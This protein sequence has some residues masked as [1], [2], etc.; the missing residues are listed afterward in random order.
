[1]SG[2]T[3]WN[4]CYQEI[5]Q[6]LEEQGTVSPGTVRLLLAHAR[7][8]TGLL[9]AEREEKVQLLRLIA[10]DVHF[11]EVYRQGAAVVAER[12]AKEMDAP[13]SPTATE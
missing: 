9:R 10:A 12:L 1:M 6:A 7:E 4:A 2:A 11:P 13:S 8:T 3:T 5:E